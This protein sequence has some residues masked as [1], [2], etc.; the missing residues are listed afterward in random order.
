MLDFSGWLSGKFKLNT[1]K[2]YNNKKAKKN[3]T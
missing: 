1:L 3:K 2:N